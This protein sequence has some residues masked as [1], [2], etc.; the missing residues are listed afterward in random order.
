MKD[1]KIYAVIGT[2]E[3]EGIIVVGEPGGPTMPLVAMDE[4]NIPL[5]KTIMDDMPR[6]GSK[7]NIILAEF[8]YSG[9]LETK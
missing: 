4:N 1:R 8:T 2:G 9:T 6:D 5:L 3:G 7:G